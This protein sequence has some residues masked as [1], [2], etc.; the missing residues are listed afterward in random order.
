MTGAGNSDATATTAA[1]KLVEVRNGWI[2]RKL[3]NCEDP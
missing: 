3:P 1:T 2:I